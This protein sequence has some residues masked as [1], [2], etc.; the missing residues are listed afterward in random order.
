MRVGPNFIPSFRDIHFLQY[1]KIQKYA[2]MRNYCPLYSHSDGQTET[3]PT[4]NICFI[5]LLFC[6]VQLF[7]FIR[8]GKDPYN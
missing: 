7:V 1:Y 4:Q 6:S 3:D 8:G 2:Y 5:F